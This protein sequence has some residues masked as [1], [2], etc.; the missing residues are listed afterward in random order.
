MIKYII[1]ILFLS[2][3]FMLAGC[4]TIRYVEKKE[5]IPVTIDD[6]LTEYVIPD[7]PPNL[8]GLAPDVSYQKLTNYTRH[9][10]VT[11]AN[12]NSRLRQIRISNCLK[13]NEILKETVVDCNVK[14]INQLE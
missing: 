10:M 4:E 3:S 2:L 14:E 7:A 13:R 12:L 8:I 5:L 1:G 11:T 6:E 9:L